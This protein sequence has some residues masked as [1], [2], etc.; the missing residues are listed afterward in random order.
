MEGKKK[1]K[2]VE[3]VRGVRPSVLSGYRFRR[4]VHHCVR[5]S[6]RLSLLFSARAF[7]KDK[8]ASCYVVCAEGGGECIAAVVLY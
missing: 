8:D 5:P 7:P 4:R 2:T 3:N 6:V 1:K